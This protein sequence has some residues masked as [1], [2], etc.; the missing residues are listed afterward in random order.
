MYLAS[1]LAC[2]PPTVDALQ[3]IGTLVLLQVKAF[4]STG[5]TGCLFLLCAIPSEVSDTE[6][7]R[8]YQHIR[9]GKVFYRLEFH[10]HHADFFC[11]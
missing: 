7:V 9:L 6:A 8:T 3:D 5:F 4:L 10:M 1:L 11:F 2:E